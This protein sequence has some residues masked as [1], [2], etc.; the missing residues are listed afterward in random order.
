MPDWAAAAQGTAA[1]L[2]A[3]LGAL[4][5]G[6]DPLTAGMLAPA[7]L[8]RPAPSAAAAAFTPDTLS[9]P[10][11]ALVHAL[12][13][14]QPHQCADT[15]RRFRDAEARRRGGLI[16]SRTRYIDRILARWLTRCARPR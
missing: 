10:P 7:A 3:L 8:S 4:A 9:R 15:G 6:L 16:P 13:D 11:D 1:D 14:L 5:Q 12:Y 2:G